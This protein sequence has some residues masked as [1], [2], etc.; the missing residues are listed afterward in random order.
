MGAMRMGYLYVGSTLFAA[1]LS[2]TQRV[3]EPKPELVIEKY[4]DGAPSRIVWMERGVPDGLDVL[5]HPNG[6]VA[7]LTSWRSGV[8][9]GM[10]KSFHEEGQ[11][12]EQG[13]YVDGHRDGLWIAYYPSGAIL[14]ETYLCNG[15]RVD[16]FR[17]WHDNCFLKVLGAFRDDERHGEWIFF[18]ERGKPARYET[19]DQGVL[20]GSRVL[21]GR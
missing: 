2:C 21:Q 9:T 13:A 19:Y 12:L 14:A 10:S 6:Q 1:A 16:Q 5:L 17:Q 8:R 11:L 15:L 7:R 18:D 3:P 20:M 4:V